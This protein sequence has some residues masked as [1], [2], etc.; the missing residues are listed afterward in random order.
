MQFANYR[1][2]IL[3]PLHIGC[4]R[5]GMVAK[6]Y[7]YV[8]GHVIT[9]ALIAAIGNQKAK[10][11]D[12]Y[13]N[14]QR[15]VLSKTRFGAAFFQRSNGEN[16]TDDKDLT[17]DEQV[18]KELVYGDH[19]VT[20][21]QDTRA[22]INGAMFEVEA[23]Y[24]KKDVYI[25]GGVWF[26]SEE[27]FG[28]NIKD[29]LNEIRIGGELKTGYGR[30]S[31]NNFDTKSKFYP[32]INNNNNKV[33]EIGLVIAKNEVLKGATLDN[34]ATPNCVV[35]NV[36]L[37]PFLG[38]RYDANLGFGRALSSAVLVRMNGIV[39]ADNLHFLPCNNEIGLGC[40]ELVK[41]IVK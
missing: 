18:E 5:A 14:I 34:E 41:K 36:P 17:Y 9:F 15:E 22:A 33:D 11:Y 12:D 16:L 35:K 39:S 38:R 20:L 29:W 8:P 27:I 37:E 10:S 32:G 24:S 40:W 25:V 21:S 26:D 13:S 1:L 3:S 23:I 31:L 19:H 28:R 2:N 6:T 30:V 4:R 7:H